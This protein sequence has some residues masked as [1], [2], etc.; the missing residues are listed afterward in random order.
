[1][2]P[3]RYVIPDGKWTSM[4]LSYQESN[5]VLSKGIPPNFTLLASMLSAQVIC[6]N[7][8]KE[9]FLIVYLHRYFNRVISCPLSLLYPHH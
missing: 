8:E 9:Y 7:G 4:P 3:V 5:F 6:M 1:M 2:A